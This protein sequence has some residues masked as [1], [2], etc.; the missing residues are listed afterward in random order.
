MDDELCEDLED[1]I[2]GMID[3]LL[4][5]NSA[6][7]GELSNRT[8][9]SACIYEETKAIYVAIISYALSKIVEKKDLWEKEGF[10]EF[11][12]FILD[13]LK[14]L[15]DV[16]DKRKMSVFEKTMKQILLKI[17]HFDE[18]FSSYVQQ[19]I[20]FSKI[21]KGVKLYEHGL[22]LSTVA[23]FLGVSKWDLMRK[24]GEKKREDIAKLSLDARDRLKKARKIFGD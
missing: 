18:K 7:L 14:K 6:K 1:T 10:D 20:E 12:D 13:K 4:V 3:A 19:V 8:I 21:Q 23:S 5:R 15:K 2:Q 22:S 9:H 16:L 24:I 11:L 17:Y